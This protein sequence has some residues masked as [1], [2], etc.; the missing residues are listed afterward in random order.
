MATEL[1]N[2]TVEF[3]RP[4]LEAEV[5]AIVPALP[6]YVL[7]WSGFVAVDR[8]G[9]QG[10]FAEA[11]RV[12]STRNGVDDVAARGDFRVETRNAL[13]A[14]QVAAIEA[15]MDAHDPSSA[16]D[17]PEQTKERQNAADVAALRVLFD[18]GIADP[19]LELTTKLTLIDA[20]ED[21]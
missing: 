5:A 14:P 13:T 8:F 17:T 16:T 7:E 21:L 4:A 2:R 15:A 10:P 1:I 3:N 18:A 20:G 9:R 6:A 11:T 19:T 12:I